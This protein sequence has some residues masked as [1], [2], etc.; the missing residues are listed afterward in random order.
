MSKT[1]WEAQLQGWE[2]VGNFL[3]RAAPAG[4]RKV[5]VRSFQLSRSW[6]GEVWMSHSCL[7][8]SPKLCFSWKMCQEDKI[9]PE[10]SR[11]IQSFA[12]ICQW[13]LHTSPEQF[14]VPAA[15]SQFQTPDFPVLV[16]HFQFQ[17]PHFLI[18][19]AQ[20]PSKLLI[21]QFQVSFPVPNSFSHSNSS[22]TLPNLSF[23]SSSSLF[24]VLNPPF[25][26]SNS[27]SLFQ[28]PHFP[29]LTVQ[30]HSK[31]LIF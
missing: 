20:T 12:G 21:F 7:S 8:H 25:P 3:G 11:N 5:P 6:C 2:F 1:S 9:S 17:T 26:S 18:Q 16:S 22:S 15:H 30:T 24:P 4:R 29:V 13:D 10:L 31:L 19:T 23:P 28:A 14:P 27:S